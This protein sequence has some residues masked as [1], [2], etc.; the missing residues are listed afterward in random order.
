[1]NTL[2]GWICLASALAAAGPIASVRADTAGRVLFANGDV[3]LVAVDGTSRRALKGARIDDGER[4]VTGAGALRQVRMV[5]GGLISLRARSE[6]G[7][8]APQ[9]PGQRPI[10][11][12]SGDV[13][14][15]T[16]GLKPSPS[17]A[18]SPTYVLKTPEGQVELQ[19]ADAI[20][21]VRPEAPGGRALVKVK[22]DQGQ[23]LARRGSNG[24]AA[25]LK[26]GQVL[27]VTAGGVAAAKSGV[28]A[29]APK[30][31]P[32]GRL[33]K[34]EPGTDAS[35]N[36]PK[37]GTFSGPP[38]FQPPLYRGPIPTIRRPIVPRRP[39]IPPVLFAVITND[40]S[41]PRTFHTGKRSTDPTV[42]VNKFGQI[43]ATVTGG[44][45]AG[46]PALEVHTLS[47]KGKI[48][49]K[50]GSPPDG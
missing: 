44:S 20:A 29:E 5:D 39:V 12:G 11:L 24:A 41:T 7:F 31:P 26:P 21:V 34:F 22:L 8:D 18:E 28:L 33:V 45:S 13:R 25:E 40:D 30:L 6:L 19:R 3:R 15:L 36:G 49:L 46:D 2:S 50:P 9:Q 14:V 47:S 1:M 48:L 35:P 32:R 38:S 10:S 23:G 43:L 37:P 42:D 27:Q 17:A 16:V 4:L